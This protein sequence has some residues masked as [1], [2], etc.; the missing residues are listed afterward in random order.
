MTR[1]VNPYEIHGP[2]NAEHELKK[3]YN[4]VIES[5]TTYFGERITIPGLEPTEVSQ[6]YRRAF[7]AYRKGDRLAA[8]RWARTAKH[9]AR[10]FWHEAKIAYLEPRTS[11]LPFL[12]G[13]TAEDYHLHEHSDTTEDLLNSVAEHIP[14]GMTEMPE[15]M[16]RYLNRAR[17]HLD[18]LEEPEY[19]NELLRAERIKAA[20]EYGRV[21][22]CMALALEAEAMKK[23]A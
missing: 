13:A 4:C 11:E 20:H 16:T 5:E 21:L 12:E 18:E 1:Q 9:L 22:E 8:E 6:T 7:R 15:E 14:P 2:E 17:K 3:A 10:A 19:R 23:A